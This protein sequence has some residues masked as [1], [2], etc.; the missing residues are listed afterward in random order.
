MSIKVGAQEMRELAQK[1]SSI[2]HEQKGRKKGE[3][4][5]AILT[6]DLNA[7]GMV[8]YISNGERKD[9]IVALKEFISR[10]ENEPEFPTPEEN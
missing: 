3:I 10:Q 4:G 5:F 6:F 7:K 1:V 9:M 8:N 2:L